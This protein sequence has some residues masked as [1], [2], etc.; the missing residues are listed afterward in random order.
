MKK[1]EWK[2]IAELV[3]IVAIVASLVF[4]GLQMRQEQVIALSELT[5]S[6]HASRVATD[7]MIAT[8]ADVWTRGNAG[9]ELTEAEQTTY[10]AIMNSYYWRHFIGWNRRLAFG[11][12]VPMDFIIAE[13]AVFLHNNPGARQHWIHMMEDGREKKVLL[14]KNYDDG[15]NAFQGAIF[16]GLSKLDEMNL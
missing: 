15:V 16:Q 1:Y 12:Q 3:G 2:D 7:D 10:R 9:D 11:Q 6:I 14:N 4:V 5:A 8:H 13:F